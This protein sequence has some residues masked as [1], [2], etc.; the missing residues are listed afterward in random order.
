[1]KIA[2]NLSKNLLAIIIYLYI[3]FRGVVILIIFLKKYKIKIGKFKKLLNLKKNLNYKILKSKIKNINLDIIVKD[4]FFVKIFRAYLTSTHDFTSH[5]TMFVQSYNNKQVIF[6][7]FNN[8][9]L[10]RFNNS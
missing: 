10:E 3:F 5:M 7:R 8:N 6:K 1:M 2:T 4:L 9:I